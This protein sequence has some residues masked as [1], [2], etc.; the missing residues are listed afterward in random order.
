MN[1]VALDIETTGLDPEHCQVVGIGI[2]DGDF[3]EP[4]LSDDEAEL[5]RWAEVTVSGLPDDR[6]LVTWNGEEF[7]LPFLA[8]RFE[9]LGIPTSLTVEPR[10]EIG[11]YG[12]PLHTCRW[13]NKRHLDIAPL[14][15]DIAIESNTQWSLK[16]VAQHVLGV[17][18]VVVDRRGASI[19]TM[20]SEQ[21]ES[22]L[23]SDIEITLGLAQ[24]AP[25]QTSQAR[26][27]GNPR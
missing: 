21:L 3:V 9:I 24:H 22:Y 10:A 27:P 11:K 12:K 18:P 17:D 2:T 4:R 14:Y 15:R 6:C 1:Y 13:A 5:L 7:D 23:R 19:A 20:E 26:S 25:V 8:R 16:P